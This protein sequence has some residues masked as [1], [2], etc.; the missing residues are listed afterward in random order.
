MTARQILRD[1][2]AR[3]NKRQ[4]EEYAAA[5][6]PGEGYACGAHAETFGGGCFNCGWPGPNIVTEK[7]QS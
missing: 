2:V 6:P 7:V 1:A 4:H 3:M 5:N